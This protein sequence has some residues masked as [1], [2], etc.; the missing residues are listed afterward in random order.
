MFMNRGKSIWNEFRNWM[1]P[2]FMSTFLWWHF[3]RTI[4]FCRALSVLTKTICIHRVR[5]FL[6]FHFKMWSKHVYRVVNNAKKYTCVKQTPRCNADLLSSLH[7]PRPFTR[8]H[9]QNSLLCVC[10]FKYFICDK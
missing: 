5:F 3:Y 9:S 1:H 7:F 4:F 6:L 2:L 8:R 10:L